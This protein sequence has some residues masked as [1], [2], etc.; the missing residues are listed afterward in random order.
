MIAR[1]VLSAVLAATLALPA[2]AAPVSTAETAKALGTLAGG[3]AARIRNVTAVPGTTIF[4]GDVVDTGS[5]G[6]AFIAL[7]GG[8]QIL[9][10]A[11]SRARLT[12]SEGPVELQVLR[13]V[14]RFRIT[15]DAPLVGK[16]A[17]ATLHADSR[18]SAIGLISL[19]APNRALIG[20]EKGELRLKTART[21]RSVVLREG[22][23][24]EVTLGPDP[25][26]PPPP[27]ATA[28][29]NTQTAIIITISAILALAIG[30]K[31]AMDKDSLT[32]SQ[33]RNLVSPFGFP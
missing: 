4:S 22:E 6:K 11:D 10:G 9:L 3:E 31:L 30:L 5:Q 21:N 20:A 25:A 8:A 27:P 12:K 13:G 16:L 28:L 15:A 24:V 17:D 18:S 14:A 33:K 2:G 7:S 26:A 19:V 1:Q 32:D 23:A 29:T